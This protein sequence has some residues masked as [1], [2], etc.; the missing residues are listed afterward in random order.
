MSTS[1]LS[2][3]HKD[4]KDS[5]HGKIEQGGHFPPDSKRYHLYLGMLGLSELYCYMSNAEEQAFSAHSVPT[6]FHDLQQL[7]TDHAQHTAQTLLAT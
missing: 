5:W 1:A 2:D 6:C 3:I 7:T 4:H